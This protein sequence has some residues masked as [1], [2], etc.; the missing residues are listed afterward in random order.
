MNRTR[1]FTGIL[2]AG[3]L[4]SVTPALMAQF[5]AMN[6]I[7]AA[8]TIERPVEASWASLSYNNEQ[9]EGERA[10]VGVMLGESS[11]GA[12]TVDSVID[13][14]P[15][16]AADLEAGDMIISINGND[17]A[18]NEEL[19][20]HLQGFAIGD[21]V[22]MGI[23]REGW[24]RTVTLNLADSSKLDLPEE[25]KELVEIHERADN[26]VLHRLEKLGYVGAESNGHKDT[27][28]KGK[29]VLKSGGEDVVI[30]LSDFE[31][32]ADLQGLEGLECLADLECLQGLELTEGEHKIRIDL[33]VDGAG[34]SNALFFGDKKGASGGSWHAIGTGHGAG[35]VHE[36]KTDVNVE[37]EAG[38]ETKIFITEDGGEVREII[39]PSSKSQI[40][41]SSA[42]GKAFIIDTQSSDGG[43]CEDKAPEC[44]DGGRC[45][46]KAPQCTEGSSSKKVTRYEIKS[47]AP[48]D[49]EHHVAGKNP[50]Q[51][52]GFFPA[53]KGK[54]GINLFPHKVET[55]HGSRNNTWLPFEAHDT[56]K[57]HHVQHKAHFPHTKAATPHVQGHGATSELEELRE[58]LNAL[59]SELRELRDALK[60]MGR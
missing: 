38:G 58:E 29:V 36:I 30:D 42:G 2:A 12:P 48:H 24:Y 54:T 32:L 46:D 8:N 47:N 33:E 21:E 52:H 26:D 45:E 27:K 40:G 23:S 41:W 39:I 17:V 44:S 59:R 15:A 34:H 31:G 37:Y 53:P 1:L 7:E 60:H 11:T 13:G 5:S 18:N 28:I 10:M 43:C 9:S 19:L 57:D 35:G 14:S 16:Q 6:I 55:K 51:A 50:H 3:T 25:P 22:V 20:G 49:L 56:F 4:L